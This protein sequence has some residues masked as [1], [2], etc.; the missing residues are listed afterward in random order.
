MDLTWSL[1]RAGYKTTFC[2]HA[3]A[4]T[5]DPETRSVYTKQMR[6]WA[7]GF[8]QNFQEHKR[9]VFR[10]PA[11]MLVVGSLLFDLL[12]LPLTYAFVTTWALRNPSS[13]KWLAPSIAIHWAISMAIVTRTI[14]WKQALV[15][16]PCYWI[17]NWWNKAIYF[18]TFIREWVLGRH[19]MSWTGRQG[20]ATEIAPMTTVRKMWLITMAATAAF[21][22]VSW[23]ST[24][25]D[26]PGPDAVLVFL[27]FAAAAAVSLS[28]FGFQRQLTFSGALCAA[29][30][31]TLWL[32]Q[33]GAT[34]VALWRVSWSLGFVALTSGLIVAVLA[35]LGDDPHLDHRSKLDHPAQ[36]W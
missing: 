26:I 23:W 12:S 33:P 4:Y 29:L 28:F 13:L 30:G 35:Y 7:S 5:Y 19:Y 22:A 15:G 34:A 6:R 31:G 20:R 9:E 8:F 2:H 36:G 16:F 32:S 10:S 24:A 1:Y 27:F 25:A 11:A 17:A 21:T 3:L 14:T 18:W